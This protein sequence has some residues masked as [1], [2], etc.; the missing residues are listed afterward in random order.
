MDKEQLLEHYF[1]HD[2]TPEQVT[3]FEN[4]LV[5]DLDF[6]KQFDFEKDLKR[7]IKTKQ[8]KNLKIA[9][10]RFESDIRETSSGGKKQGYKNWAFAASIV[11]LVSIG[12]LGYN[13]FMRTDYNAMYEENF[14]NYPNTVFTITRGDTSESLERDAF[15]AYEA[16][17]FQNALDNFDEIPQNDQKPY[18]DFYK[19]QS[20]LHLNKTAEAKKYFI[21]NIEKGNSFIPESHWYLALTYLKEKDKKHALVELQK[22]ISQ[23]DYNKN[24]AKVLLNK[25]K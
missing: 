8:N 12:W 4:L 15:A 14:Q 18:L 7:V 17:N 20:Y 16:E 9:L 1:S 24:K 10:N 21:K 19:A 13:N 23:Y 11:L 25:L 3:L 6:K 22:L 5:T 2:L